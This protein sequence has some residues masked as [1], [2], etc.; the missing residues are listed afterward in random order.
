MVGKIKV[1]ILMRAQLKKRLLN[2]LIMIIIQ[3]MKLIINNLNL[4]KIQRKLRKNC[5]IY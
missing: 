4:I 3:M 5:M 2:F 1:K